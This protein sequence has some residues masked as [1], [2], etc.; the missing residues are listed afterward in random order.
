MQLQVFLLPAVRP[1]SLRSS[2][3]N[4]PHSRGRADPHAA[5]TR[6]WLEDSNNSL[7]PRRRT[8]REQAVPQR[9][10]RSGS[11]RLQDAPLRQQWLSHDAGTSLSVPRAGSALC[12]YAGFL[13]RRN[14]LRN[15]PRHARIVAEGARQR[16]CGPQG[17][18]ALPLRVQGDRFLLLHDTRPRRARPSLPRIEGALSAERTD[19]VPP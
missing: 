15:L 9:G 13:L 4:V 16:L 1:H 11:I 17:S 3:E 6:R 5:T 10:R 2:T 12:R 14:L 19:H 8:L 7:D 18:W